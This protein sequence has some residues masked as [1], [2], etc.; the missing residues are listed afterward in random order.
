ML[1]SHNLILLFKKYGFEFKK[2]SSGK[3]FYAFTYKTGF[4]HNA[5]FVY[6]DDVSFEEMEKSIKSL[7]EIGFSTKKSHYKSLSDIENNLFE[8]FF[9]VDDWKTRIKDEYN[10]YCEK[11]LSIL[12]DGAKNY[13]Y[14]QVPY[15]K[16]NHERIHE[17]SIIIDILNEIKKT[18]QN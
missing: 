9:N 10:D 13:K 2:H 6:N 17:E 12:P 1:D 15:E 16:E 7:N 18:N 14:V 11:M 8:G 5:E 3:G 4:F